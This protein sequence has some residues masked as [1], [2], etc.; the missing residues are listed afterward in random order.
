MVVIASFGSAS[1]ELPMVG[2]ACWVST[3]E[4]HIQDSFHSAI[5]LS[6]KRISHKMPE[7]Q[8]ESSQ[9]YQIQTLPFAEITTGLPNN[10]RAESTHPNTVIIDGNRSCPLPPQST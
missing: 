9:T 5:P 6:L 2:Q 7:S 8:L 1:L 10:M 4:K 3:V